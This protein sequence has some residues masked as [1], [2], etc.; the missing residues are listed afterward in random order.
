MPHYSERLNSW[1]RITQQFYLS[2][3]EKNKFFLSSSKSWQC[4]FVK[5]LIHVMPTDDRSLTGTFFGWTMTLLYLLE[6]KQKL[7]FHRFHYFVIIPIIKQ[8]M[9]VKWELKLLLKQWRTDACIQEDELKLHKNF[10]LLTLFRNIY[11]CNTT[12]CE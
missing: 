8:N 10:L 4:N 3:F 2:Q 12:R 9:H 7:C 1:K 11:I 6:S 5:F